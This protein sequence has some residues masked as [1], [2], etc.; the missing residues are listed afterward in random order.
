MK[1]IIIISLA[2]AVVVCMANRALAQES[3]STATEE[4]A[5]DAEPSDEES[6]SR[7][8]WGISVGGGPLLGGW[9]GGAGGIDAR[10][11]MQLDQLLGIYAQPI[12]LVGAGASVDAEGASAAGLATV[13][14]GALAD[15]TLVDLVYVALGPE[16]LFGEFGSAEVEINSAS[17]KAASGAFFS[18]ASRAGIA[19]GSMEPTGR[20]AFAIGLDMHI[21]FVDG[22][23]I[24]PMIFLG[25]ESF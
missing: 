10:F 4:G 17:A 12:A 3:A 14:V 9:E 5:A 2:I 1:K 20:S 19:L 21:V 18:I 15:I 25:Y 7:F 13:G 24:M 8:R 11:G 22:V 16:L 23:A 6:S